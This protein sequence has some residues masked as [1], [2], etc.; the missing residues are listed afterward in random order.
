M[1]AAR[2]GYRRLC[3]GPPGVQVLA[4]RRRCDDRLSQRA[5]ARAQHP[6]P[7]RTNLFKQFAR[8]QPVGLG[9]TAAGALS[10]W[11][12][13]AHAQ[14]LACASVG[15]RLLRRGHLRGGVQPGGRRL[16]G[17]LVPAAQVLADRL[18]LPQL[19]QARPLAV[20]VGTPPP[21]RAAHP[22]HPQIPGARTVPGRPRMRRC[23]V[24]AC[25]QMAWSR[26]Q[27]ARDWGLAAAL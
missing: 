22:R 7:I 14:L 6:A 3:R 12:Y 10:R 24:T 5:T 13:P 19:A 17:R 25:V 23:G 15:H 18:Q 26:K 20:V 27:T 2:A 8:R 9:A 1:C 4:C 16:L 11:R 21:Q